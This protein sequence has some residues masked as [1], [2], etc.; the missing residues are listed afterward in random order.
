MSHLADSESSAADTSV[1]TGP[2][3][4]VD[5]RRV[6]VVCKVVCCIVRKKAGCNQ[7]RSNHQ[8][9]RASVTGATSFGHSVQRQASTNPWAVRPRLSSEQ[10]SKMAVPPLKRPLRRTFRPSPC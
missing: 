6:R 8:N 5:E 7:D 9:V 2:E 10:N 1:V 3:L 4:P